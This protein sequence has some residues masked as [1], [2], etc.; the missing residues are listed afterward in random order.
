[1]PRRRRGD[2]AAR[3]PPRSWRQRCCCRTCTCRRRDR[4]RSPHSWRSARGP[5]RRASAVYVP[6]RP[7][8][9]VGRR[10]P[11]A[12]ARSHAASARPLRG[13]AGRRRSAF[14]RAAIATS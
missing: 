6:R 8:R 12:H 13:I 14:V 4:A 10:R 3:A 2:R 7:L 1:M 11:S 9:L 5:A